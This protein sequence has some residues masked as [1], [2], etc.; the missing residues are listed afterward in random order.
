FQP[1]ASRQD[2]TESMY[3]KVRSGMITVSLPWSVKPFDAWVQVSCETVRLGSP[4][5]TPAA[6]CASPPGLD[7]EAGEV[8]ESA[9]GEPPPD[10]P[11]T[12]ITTIRISAAAAP[13]MI[14][15]VLLVPPWLG[16]IG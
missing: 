10:A 13:K 4:S 15:G 3:L 9:L 2:F 1:A 5:T 14:S 6:D 11:R 12:P 7:V 16:R 8:P